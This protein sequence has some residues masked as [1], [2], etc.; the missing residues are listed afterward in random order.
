MKTPTL[1]ELQELISKW[2][3]ATFGAQT[4]EIKVKK[5]LKE[6]TELAKHP[7]DK[8]EIADV[9]IV[10]LQ[11]AKGAGMSADDLIRAGY[12][13]HR[14]NELR[15]WAVDADGCHQHV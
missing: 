8:S 10:L 11:V 9:M 6:V 5:L 3:D 13:K 15:S 14:I 4:Q 12:D 7:R 2:A 1:H